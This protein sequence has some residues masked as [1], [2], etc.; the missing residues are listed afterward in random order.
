MG[1]ENKTPFAQQAATGSWV[2]FII[3]IVMLAVGRKAMP[4]VILDLT[5]I[6]FAI[7]GIVA[8]IIALFGIHKYGAKKILAP[9]LIGIILNGF[10]VLIWIMN[11]MQVLTMVKR[12]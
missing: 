8:G 4:V 1:N 3:I 10:L 12:G 5:A 11:F 2:S 7:A 6:I 9:A